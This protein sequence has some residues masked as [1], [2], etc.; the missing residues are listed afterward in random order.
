MR[1]FKKRTLLYSF[2]EIP[3][4]RMVVALAVLQVCTGAF[5][6]TLWVWTGKRLWLQYYFD[7]QG[8][9]YF[10]LL[11]AFK[12]WLSISAWREFRQKESM[13]SAWLAI[14]VAMGFQLA[15]DLLKH[16]L[17]VDTYIN[18]LHYVWSRWHLFPADILHTWGS[19]LAGPIFMA[20]LAVGLYQALQYCHKINVSGKLRPLD[21]GLIAAVAIY[22]LYVISYIF[23]DVL[24]HDGALRIAAVLTWPND[25]LLAILMAEAVLL[26]R[27]AFEMGDGYVARTWGAF[28]AAIFLTSVESFG[29]WLA[30]FG[31]FPYPENSVLWY[32]WFVWAAAFAIAPAYQVDAVRVAQN[33]IKSH[34]AT[35]RRPLMAYTA[36]TG[37]TRVN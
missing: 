2:A 18:P 25:L 4:S 20:I 9:A 36:A 21:W 6:H 15:G 28:A 1:F 5:F 17:A 19:A 24:G 35:P 3:Y 13:R 26:T 30:V 33:R 7:Y 27:T 23:N 14:S 31:Y 29:H 11:D 37:Q 22:G 34:V 16:W 8:A 10:I 32:L 12:L